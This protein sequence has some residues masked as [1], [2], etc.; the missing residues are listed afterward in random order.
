MATPATRVLRLPDPPAPADFRLGHRRWLDGLRGVAILLVLAE[1][2]RVVKGG[3]VGVDVF[4]VLSGFL[5]TALLAEEWRDRGAISL[6]RFYL[7][8]AL[9][10]TPALLL[11][12]L[13][14]LLY[15]ALFRP[16]EELAAYRREMVVAACYASNW[17][18]VHGVPM[19]TLGHTWSLSVE[20]QFYLLWPAALLVLLRLGAGPRGLAAVVGIGVLASAAWRLWLHKLHR[21]AG[22]PTPDTEF[23]HFARLYAGLDTRA[24]ALL[25]GCLVGL[26]AA[27]NLLPRSRRFV[28][29]AGPAALAAVALLGYVVLTRPM[30]QFYPKLFTGYFTLVALA[31]GVVL[32]RLLSAPSRVAAAILESAPLVWAGRL[33]YGL[34]L[35]HIP[36]FI[37]VHPG[38]LAGEA[39]AGAA[40][41]A[42]GVTFAL[43]LASYHLVE[44]PCLR[45]K[46][47]LG[48]R[49]GP[50][51]AAPPAD[52]PPVARAA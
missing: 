1:H 46:A 36:A 29:W 13:G 3:Y 17:P 38:V 33:S 22:P 49:A 2:L 51:A 34:Y 23:A 14:C 43:A 40:V 9:R 48:H 7:R 5:I 44:R 6:R 28:R 27:G 39:P 10:L 30:G 47:R 50:P 31:V 20:E 42:V 24:D 35:Y 26:L 21:A 45:L 16:P 19:P 8:R 37:W 52:P 32:V 4:F 12:L 18:S 15:T 11:L 41:L 25:V